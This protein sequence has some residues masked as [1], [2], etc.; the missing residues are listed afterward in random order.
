MDN[1][2]LLNFRFVDRIEA[3]KTIRDY[4]HSNSN[5]PPLWIL[6]NKGVGITRLINEVISKDDTNEVVY[7][8]CSFNDG[9]DLDRISGLIAD[10]QEKAK[11]KIS[12]F[13]TTNYSQ[14]FDISKKIS[15]QILKLAGIDVSDFVA[16]FYDSSKIF[17]NQKQQQHSSQ[18]VLNSYIS[19]IIKRKTLVVILEHFPCCN[20]NSADFFMQIIMNFMDTSNIYFIITST[21]DELNSNEDF[22]SDLLSKIPISRLEIMPL[23]EIYFYEIL[24]DKFLIPHEARS[25]VSQLSKLCEGSPMRLHA[26]LTNMFMNGSIKFNSNTDTAEMDLD[27]LKKT[28]YSKE[29]SFDYNKLDLFKKCIL[30]LII[31]FKEQASWELLITS[32]SHIIEKMGKIQ[33][34]EEEFSAAAFELL[35]N[36]IINRDPDNKV[37]I[38]NPLIRDT[39]EDVICQEP[40]HRLFSHWM[41]EYLLEN[42]EQIVASGIS[43]ELLEY[44]IVLHSIIGVSPDWVEQAVNYGISQYD[45]NHIAVAVEILDHV[46]K[47]VKSV[48]SDKL[49]I[50]ANCYYQNGNY[51]TAEQLLQLVAY[52]NDY[53]TW[54]F[55]YSYCKV[56]NLLLKKDFALKLAQNAEN[57]SANIVEQIKALNMQQQILVDTSDGKE[58]A[59][60]IFNRLIEMS[61]NSDEQV[62]IAI[63]PTLKCAI[64]F[65]HGK[66]AL[67]YL[68]HAEKKA[69]ILK[70]QFEEA[71]ILTN[72]GFEYFRQGNP[73]DAKNCFNR[74]IELLTNLRIHEISYPLNNLANY[75]MSKDMFQNA[76][77]IITKANMWNTSAYVSISLKTLLMVCYAHT[78]ERERSIKLASELIDFIKRYKITDNTMLRKIYLN[79][80][81]VY[82]HLNEPESVINEYAEK[83]YKLSANTSSWYRAYDIARKILTTNADPLSHCLPGEEWYWTN[84]K[85]EPWLVTFSHD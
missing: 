20:K 70:D 28:V 11:M 53:E 46:K 59:A 32:S 19:H 30:R 55:Y 15:T 23:D 16:S 5:N 79:I 38:T 58:A 36:V 47:E 71:L 29:L 39:I 8:F 33:V 37:K 1:R 40:I 14:I 26:A 35:F 75:Y 56:E 69:I 72:K 84:G 43:E 7:V 49:T 68:D 66:D 57:K 74:S 25:V 4:L 45:K 31:A 50:I 83:A 80:A 51:E 76:I 44:L 34:K 41:L 10:L 17:V 63:L 67:G 9:N 52:R 82:K 73:T 22:A 60:R 2:E 48:A 65:F 13:I 27:E 21:K 85:Y 3:Q 61:D 6:G 81:I 62:E 42:K 12:D 78:S 77:T 24:H 64:D 54:P 18:K